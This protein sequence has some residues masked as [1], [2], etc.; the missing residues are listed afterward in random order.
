MLIDMHL[1][2]SRYSLCSHM[3]PYDMVRK[4]AERGLD[5]VVITDHNRIWEP[6]E[7]E[8]LSGRAGGLL[9]F[10][11]AE[12][13]G[14]G[15]GHFLVYGMGAF[16]AGIDLYEGVEEKAFIE[17]VHSLGGVVVCAHPYRYGDGLEAGFLSLP[18]DGVEIKSVNID[19]AGMEKA[20]ALA[21]RLDAFVI[22]GSDAH[23]TDFLGCYCTEYRARITNERELVAALKKGEF[24]PVAGGR[25]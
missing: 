11:G 24:T 5:G 12:V 23:T 4:A 13:T 1:H 6:G 3:D 16:T 15:G 7:I 21:A 18:L 2:T 25:F 20:R 22:A 19:N 14:S 10:A 8:E 17:K 9:V